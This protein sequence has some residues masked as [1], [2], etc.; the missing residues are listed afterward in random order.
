MAWQDTYVLRRPLELPAGSRLSMRFVYDNSPRNPRA[1]RPSRR[2]TFGQTTSSEMGD[3][4]IQ[5]LPLDAAERPRLVT[6]V[7]AKMLQSDIA[8]VEKMIAADPRDSRLRTDLAFCYLEAGRV[9]DALEQLRR[10]VALAPDSAFHHHDLAVV[11]IRQKRLQEAEEHLEAA[12]RLKPDFGD[13][14]SNLGVVS[15]ARRDLAAAMQ[16]FERSLAIQ[17]RDAVAHHN[18]GSIYA[19]RRD[20]P[21]A[22]AHL[23]QAVALR[24]HDKDSLMALAAVLHASGQPAEAVAHYRRALTVDADAQPALV[25]LAW[26]LA[27]ARDPSVRNPA[28]AVQLAERARALSSSPSAELFDALGAA[29]AADGQVDRAIEA[30]TQAV[31]RATGPAMRAEL[32]QRLDAYRR[33]RERFPR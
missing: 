31:A 16:W 25:E 5:L 6:E 23:E 32:Q 13:A 7:A 26:I 30:A 28:E 18:L 1:P 4:W 9:E 3:L 19:Q 29:Y 12:V 33:L 24:P 14:Y 27:T 8:G 21:S 22:R 17:P 10:A 11:L 20:L 2:V 15:Y